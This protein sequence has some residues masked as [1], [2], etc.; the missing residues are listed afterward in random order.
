MKVAFWLASIMFLVQTAQF[1][2][3][4]NLTGSIPLFAWMS[5]LGVVGISTGSP[6]VME[7]CLALVE[8]TGIC[9]CAD[10][11]TF[12]IKVGGPRWSIG[13][14][15]SS[16]VMNFELKGCWEHGGIIPYCSI[17]QLAVWNKKV[18]IWIWS[19]IWSFS[20]WNCQEISPNMI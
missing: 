5:H 14:A 18:E 8:L 2:E 12:L 17:I 19:L 13:K 16:D 11:V 10:G 1:S 3:E 7:G 9:P 20:A 6:L 15:G 4:V